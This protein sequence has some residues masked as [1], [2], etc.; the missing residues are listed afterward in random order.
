MRQALHSV[1]DR[2][3]RRIAGDVRMIIDVDPVGML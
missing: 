1:R 3:R 2:E